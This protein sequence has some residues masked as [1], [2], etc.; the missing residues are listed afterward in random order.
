[1]FSWLLSLMS[2]HTQIVPFAFFLSLNV[3]HFS[4]SALYHSL[5]LYLLALCCNFFHPLKWIITLITAAKKSFSR[6]FK[7]STKNSLKLLWK[8]VK[9][10]KREWGAGCKRE[11]GNF[12]SH[13]TYFPLRIYT[14]CATMNKIKK[15]LEINCLCADT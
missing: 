2:L 11:R 8:I 3:S 14:H 4:M 10:V 15:K 5:S 9:Y 12:I 6:F 7:E 1:M 13:L